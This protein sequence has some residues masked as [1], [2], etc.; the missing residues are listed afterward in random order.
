M[1]ENY[2]QTGGGRHTSRPWFLE[3]AREPKQIE[4]KLKR[5]GL[6]YY[7]DQVIKNKLIS[8]YVLAQNLYSF[9]KLQIEL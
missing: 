6:L 7:I 8:E 5:D 9:T 2:P 4:F 3:K 1:P